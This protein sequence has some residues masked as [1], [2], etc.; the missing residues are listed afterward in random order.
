MNWYFGRRKLRTSR[1]DLLEKVSQW[2]VMI[3]VC[4]DM[5]KLRCGVESLYLL[6]FQGAMGVYELNNLAFKPIVPENSL[7]KQAA[8][9]CSSAAS[10]MSLD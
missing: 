1:L 2:V 8:F 9:R 3:T 5:D 7:L 4:F 6:A 10:R